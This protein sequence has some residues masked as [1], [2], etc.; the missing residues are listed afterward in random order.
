[1]KK[2][3]KIE[4]YDE[5]GNLMNSGKIVEISKDKSRFIFQDSLGYTWT[6]LMYKDYKIEIV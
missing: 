5:N 1:M 2:G 4:I 6:S 3:A